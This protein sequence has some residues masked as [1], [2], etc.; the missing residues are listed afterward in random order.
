MPP[1]KSRASP[2]KQVGKNSVKFN[3]RVI[4]KN[5]LPA[6]LKEYYQQVDDYNKQYKSPLGL[7]RHNYLGPGNTARAEGNTLEPVDS[8]DLI[9]QEHDDAYHYAKTKEDVF[10]ADKKAI[11]E[12]ASDAWKNR[13]WH[14]AVGAVGLGIKHGVERLSDKVYYP[15]LPGESCLAITMFA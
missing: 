4:S 6:D 15:S 10:A 2:P 14:S 3:N 11:H 9:A 5:Y 7:P 13:N 1:V 12:F 8:D